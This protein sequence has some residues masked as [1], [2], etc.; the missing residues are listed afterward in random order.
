M[1]HIHEYMS[2]PSKTWSININIKKIENKGRRGEKQTKKDSGGRVEGE[3]NKK[4][5]EIL[6]E[7]MKYFRYSTWDIF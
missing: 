1:S 6:K 2:R 4:N 5:Y 3:Y 7:L